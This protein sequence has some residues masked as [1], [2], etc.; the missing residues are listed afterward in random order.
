MTC[1]SPRV[2][3][4]GASLAA[5]SAA[6]ADAPRL[7]LRRSAPD[8]SISMASPVGAALACAALASAAFAAAALAV[9][10]PGRISTL[11]AVSSTMPPAGKAASPLDSAAAPSKACR[12]RRK[13]WCFGCRR[14]SRSL[15]AL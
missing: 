9:P 12:V 2:E 15:S 8:R 10:S 3:L 14:P 7:R 6:T 13:T 11:R 4:R 5:L 1:A